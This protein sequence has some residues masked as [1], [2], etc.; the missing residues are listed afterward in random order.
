MCYAQMLFYI[1]QMFFISYTQFCFSRAAVQIYLCSLCEAHLHIRVAYFH[2]EK[3]LSV[4]HSVYLKSLSVMKGKTDV[5]TALCFLSFWLAR[6]RLYIPVVSLSLAL[7]HISLLLWLLFFNSPWFSF[8]L[9]S[10]LTFFPI[11]PSL[12]RSLALSQ[13]KAENTQGSWCN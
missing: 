7:S 4:A 3:H 9:L 11:F 5:F 2:C 1:L 10:L 13:W 12:S 6:W 8:Y